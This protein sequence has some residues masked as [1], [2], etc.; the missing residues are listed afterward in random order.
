MVLLEN[1]FGITD[2]ADSEDDRAAFEGL[3]LAPPFDQEN[4]IIGV[5]LL[6]N[7]AA[8]QLPMIN[9]LV[10]ETTTFDFRLL[11]GDGY[12]VAPDQNAT[13]FTITDDNGGPGVGP[14]IGLSVSETSLAEGD[15]FTV[16]FAVDGAIPAGG[17]DVLVTSDESVS[18]PLGQFELSNLDALQLSGV[19]NLRPGDDRGQSFIA[20]ITEA[21]AYITLDVF[22]DIVA[23]EPY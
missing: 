10:E 2:Q 12:V 8:I 3:G 19:S 9:D 15:T 6:E 1:L 4:N 20:T 13:L 11:E 16:N 23:E 22:D 21:N 18:G 5:R 14:T 17:I 7:Q